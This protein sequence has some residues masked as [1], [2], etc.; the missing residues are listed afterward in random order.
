MPGYPVTAVFAG[1]VE[2]QQDAA[3]PIRQVKPNAADQLG[4]SDVIGKCVRPPGTEGK[5]LGLIP[6]ATVAGGTRATL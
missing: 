5:R 2:S 1:K 3:M 4:I 6:G